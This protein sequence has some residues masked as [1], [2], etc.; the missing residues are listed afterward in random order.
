MKKLFN[1]RFLIILASS[2]VGLILLVIGAFYLFDDVDDSFVKSGY[3]LNPLSSTSEKYFFDENVGYR[4]NLS[5]MIEF[6]DVDDNKVSVVRDSFIHYNDDSLSFLKNGAILDLDSIKGN[7][8][9]LFYNITSKSMI[10]KTE[11]GYVIETVNGEIK[12]KNFIGR[13]SDNKYIVVGDLNLKMAGNATSI[14]GEYFEIV[15]AEE[16]VVNI[17]NKDVKYQVAAADTLIYV[18]SN[19]VIDLGNK[20]ITVDDIDVMSITAIT[21][22]GDENIEII[23]KAPEEDE[24]KEN[25]DDGTGNEND[26]NVGGEGT[27][28]GN[29]PGGEGTG[30]TGNTGVDGEIVKEV[31]VSLKDADIG[32]TN[33]NVTFDILNATEE[34]L[35]KLQVVN[36]SSGKTVDMVAQ[37]LEN[38]EIQVNLL[39]PNTKYLFMV[40]NEKDNNKYFQKV[41]E[42]TSFGIKL[43]KA[44]ATDSSLAFRVTIE[45]G[46]DITNAKLSL[47]KFNEETMQNEIVTTSY[48]D[49]ISGEIIVQEK[50]TNLSSLEGKLEGEHE[51]IYDGLDNNTI[52]TAVLDEFSLASSNF[53][54]IYNVTVTAMTLKKTPEFS[55][56]TV[57]KNVGAG[58]F[59]LSLGSIND[60]DNAIVSYTYMIYDRFDDT[61]AIDPIVHSNASP[62]T[63]LIGNDKNELKND[64]NY[65]YKVIIEYFDNE[66]HIEYV[67]SDSII[68]NMGNEPYITVVPKE[69]LISYNQ[70]GATIYLTDNSCLITMPG[71]E[72][73]AGV[74]TARVV[75]SE[76]DPSDGDLIQK[77][78]KLIN[79]EVTDDE[80]KYDLFVEGL[81][82]GTT[83]QID[84]KAIFNDSN[85]WELETVLHTDESKKLIATKSFTTFTV[86]W[87]RQSGHQERPII[88]TTQLVGDAS[89]GTLSPEESAAVIEQVVLKLFPGRNIKDIESKLPMVSKTYNNSDAFNIKERFYDNA[90][91]ITND[92]TFGLTAEKLIE[93]SPEG[94]LNEYYTIVIEAYTAGGKAVNLVNSV[95][96]YRVSQSLF[97]N[98]EATL[99]VNS[100]NNKDAGMIY[101][102]LKGSTIVGYTASLYFAR[103]TLVDEFKL[104]PRKINYYVYDVDKKPLDFFVKNEDGSL[105]QVDKYTVDIS[106]NTENNFKFDFYLDHYSTEYEIVD[107]VLRRG[108]TVYVGYEIEV[109]AEDRSVSLYPTGNSDSPSGYGLYKP[110]FSNKEEPTLQAYV[111]SS[112]ENSIT[113]RYNLK[114]T[115]NA[116]Y[117]LASSENYSFYYTVGSMGVEKTLDL[118]KTSLHEFAGE[119]TLN[120]LSKGSVYSLYYKRNLQKSGEFSDDVIPYKYI[121]GPTSSR[122]FDGYYDMKDTSK[123]NFNYQIINNPLTDNK[124]IIKILADESVLDRILSYNVSFKSKDDNG[125]DIVINKELWNLSLCSDKDTVARCLSVDYLELKSMQST[126][127]SDRLIYVD[128]EALYDNG[129]TGYDF[130]VGGENADYKYFIMQR[131]DQDPGNELGFINYLAYTSTGGI[132]VWKDS[133][134]RPK[135]YYTYKLSSNGKNITYTSSIGSYNK[136]IGVN[137]SFNGYYS[138]K[139]GSLYPKMVS[140]DKMGCYGGNS[141]GC[142]TFSFSSITPS[143]RTRVKTSMI[144]GAVVTLDL[145]S[146]DVNDIKKETDGGRYLYIDVWDNELFAKYVDDEQ[147]HLGGTVY[148]NKFKLTVRPTVK[149]KLDDDNDK[150]N[151]TIYEAV[152]DGLKEYTKTTGTYYYNVYAYMNKSGKYVYTQL[153][154]DIGTSGG[155][156]S[157]FEVMTYKLES[158]MATQLF[159]NLDTTIPSSEQE[160]GVRTLISKITLD[161]YKNGLAYNFDIIYVLCDN[162]NL[163]NCGTKEEGKNNIYEKVIP[164]SDIATIME[165]KDNVASYNLEYNKNYVMYIYAKTDYYDSENNNK[166]ITRDIKINSYDYEV[167]LRELVEPKFVVTRNAVLDNDDYAIDFE[168]TVDDPDKTLVGGKY[169]IKLTDTSGA[170]VGTMKLLDKDNA[171]YEV[172]NYQDYVFDAT[173]L[174][175]AAEKKVR[176]SGLDANTSYNFIVYGE[177]YLNNYGKEYIDDSSNEDDNYE[178]PDGTIVSNKKILQVNKQIPVFTTANYGVAFGNPAI[179]VTKKSVVVTF[180]GGSNFD[181]VTEVMYSI[182][183]W[184]DVD[185]ISTVSGSFV[186]GEDG[187]YFEK[188]KDSDDWQLT[189]NPDKMNNDYGTYKVVISFIVKGSTET[190]S[191]TREVPY[192]TED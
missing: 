142:N 114:D 83:Y 87:K 118:V 182:G 162:S 154:N 156:N 170:V 64:T 176:I 63:V 107:D 106:E 128:V 95:F 27:G 180:L 139:F 112:T 89:T 153:F 189:I 4:E 187:K 147:I 43:E 173:I 48:T 186:I 53:K 41:F 57:E 69:E 183:L 94:K 157:K 6:N 81:D 5:S 44:Y 129:I 90:F 143:V 31:V 73:C 28:E 88:A 7:S 50:I 9:V 78:S 177:A 65:Y 16:G 32:S 115:D 105:E 113:Y 111:A 55:E 75:V 120:D 14:K 117:K 18:G 166:K 86:D 1:S 23:P 122:L 20:K 46:T 124:V 67:T 24:D 110:I 52:Y 188:Y 146:T 159:K 174:D 190:V 163:D 29:Q 132:D 35:F 171:F 123:Y 127:S 130:K 59:E 3:V 168:I 60:P 181:N 68:F 145:S 134:G 2:L 85:D 191:F 158:L 109:V 21:I 13:I 47:Y 175:N 79:F 33:I 160:Y 36:L 42:T 172:S 93:R 97:A 62:L 144:N 133:L 40:I 167:P 74:S 26:N 98:A 49:P 121:G 17:E 150:V 148:D 136:N 178:L 131:I 99:E 8:T 140:S 10:Q 84:V 126:G 54:D 77:Y 11:S 91:N 72:K 100:F 164:R 165:V 155:G 185:N 108:N 25:G 104:T 103:T 141:T 19:K 39:T 116:V 82:A 161:P 15:Y 76:K 61:L 169:Y 45:E 58:S 138:D 37:V 101:S 56:M 12:L 125:K 71:R 149:V 102:D 92:G 192:Y 184:D 96:E 51:I 38:V 137:L 80:I 179:E 66:K 135:G 151:D 152:I 119:V 22:D 34:D 30:G 70:I